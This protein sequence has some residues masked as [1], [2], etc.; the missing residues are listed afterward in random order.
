MARRG[1]GASRRR[2]RTDSP[3]VSGVASVAAEAIIS[4]FGAL[5]NP[6]LAETQGLLSPPPTGSPTALRTAQPFPS[7]RRSRFP[8]GRGR[9]RRS[10][11]AASPHVGAYVATLTEATRCARRGTRCAR[12]STHVT[13]YTRY[14]QASALVARADALLPSCGCSYRHLW[15]SQP[16]PHEC[17]AMPRR[18]GLS[19]CRQ[20]EQPAG[21]EKRVAPAPRGDGEPA[22][23]LAR[24]GGLPRSGRLMGR[25]RRGLSARPRGGRAL[26]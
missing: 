23:G 25:I 11:T 16:L 22:L 13:L 6:T 17:A 9:F 18:A 10:G 2:P 5:V 4:H 24:Q 8:G 3:R 1:G 15:V 12:A 26:R 21:R 20:S 14:P 19:L 7:L